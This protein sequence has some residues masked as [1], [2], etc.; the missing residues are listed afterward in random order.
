MSE[1]IN[2]V[3]VNEKEYQVIKTGRAQAEQV[4]GLTR[5]IYKHGAKAAKGMQGTNVADT[6]GIAFIGELIMSLDADALIDLFQVLVGCP[7][8]DAELYF[9]VATLVEVVIEVYERQPSVKRLVERFFSNGNSTPTSGELP[10]K[11]E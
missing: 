11:S 3:V 6:T 5:W 8:E 7:K 9:D 2:T 4:L 1:P 10:T